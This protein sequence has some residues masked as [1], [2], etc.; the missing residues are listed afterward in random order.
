MM[1]NQEKK[2]VVGSVVGKIQK[3]T[4]AHVKHIKREIKK[5]AKVLIF[6]D[7]G[8]LAE[9]PGFEPGRHLSHPTPLAG[10]TKMRKSLENKGL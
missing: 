2:H 9:K 5:Y 4:C 8:V 6:W 10:A 7:F 1:E 3:H